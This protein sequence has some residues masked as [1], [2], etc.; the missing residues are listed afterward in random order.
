MKTIALILVL[1]LAATA[2]AHAQ[3]PPVENLMTL[4]PQPFSPAH[5]FDCWRVL[6]AD[7]IT[8]EL[9]VFNPVNPDFDG[10]GSQPVA[11]VGGFWAKFVHTPGM[12]ILAVRFPAPVIDLGQ[13]EFDVTF[14]E[15]VP[16]TGDRV[17]L[18]EVDV[19]FGNAGFPLPDYESLPCYLGYNIEIDIVPASVSPVAGRL[20]Y[21]DADDPV[22]P[23]V[24]CYDTPEDY[25]FRFML[26]L[27]P[28]AAEGRVWGALKALYR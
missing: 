18:A 26:T 28:V 23:T 15:P 6:E 10:G 16:V 4:K 11:F 9:A 5:D 17:V 25:D 19:W 24:A 13:G 1:I 3:T 12:A 2:A 14:T 7:L 27:P 8:L 20:V 22:D 21:G